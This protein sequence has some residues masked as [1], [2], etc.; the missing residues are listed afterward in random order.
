M[1]LDTVKLDRLFLAE[2]DHD[3]RAERF[4]QGLLELTR[5]LGLRTI[6]EGVERPGQLEVLRRHGCDLVQ[7]HLVC[8]AVPAAELTARVLAGLPLLEPHGPT[9]PAASPV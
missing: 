7:G 6:A 8:R 3:G 9:L 5:H 1:P 4:L 2:V